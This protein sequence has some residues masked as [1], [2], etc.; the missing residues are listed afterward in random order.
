MNLILSFI[1]T[2]KP[3]RTV[4]PFDSVRLDAETVRETSKETL[5][6][7]HRDHQWEVDG[8]RYFR[9]DATSSVRIHFER[10][11][12]RFKAIAKSRSFGPFGKF[13][14]IDGIAYTDDRVF[15]FVDQRVGDWFCYDDGRHWA[16]M[17]V[18]DA[19]TAV[20]DVLASLAA[21]APVLSGVVGFWQ[22]TKLLYL[23]RAASIRAR[24]EQFL[25]GDDALDPAM[26]TTVTLEPHSSPAVRKAQLH[27]EYE[28]ASP[29][30]PATYG[31]LHGSRVRTAKLIEKA[32][33]TVLRARLLA[34]QAREIR[35][36]A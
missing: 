34:A 32:T 36:A 15:A 19:S 5:V 24:L 31:F 13:S 33:D 27:A 3:A 26:V 18:K 9:L 35:G 10:N 21:F 25:R 12:V 17:V 1:H 22:D 7:H 28:K 6:A 23:G 8:Q 2:T 20:R 16:I 11:P 30:L 4:G 29:T 14:A